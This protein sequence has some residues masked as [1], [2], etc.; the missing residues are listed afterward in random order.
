MFTKKYFFRLVEQLDFG[1][2]F[3]DSSDNVYAPWTW[4]YCQRYISGCL[5]NSKKS[6]LHNRK[7]KKCLLKT[8]QSRPLI[9]FF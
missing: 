7:T 1:R 4:Q 2:K 9:Y 8:D 6:I 3:H 5:I